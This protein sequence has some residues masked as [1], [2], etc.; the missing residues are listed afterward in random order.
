[1]TPSD[2]QIKGDI[3]GR[4]NPDGTV[5]GGFLEV[6]HKIVEHE[7]YVVPETSLRSGYRAQR[8]DKKGICT[9]KVKRQQRIE[10]LAL[11]DPH[12]D[13]LYLMQ[14]PNE[15]AAAVL[16][17]EE[18][19]SESDGSASDRHGSDDSDGDDNADQEDHSDV[20]RFEELEDFDE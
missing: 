3:L 14:Y 2:D 17:I 11:P 7:G 16:D 12:E 18:I 4:E 10:S 1:M 6:L 5:T 9:A 20:E 8:H 13:A 19:E 15:H